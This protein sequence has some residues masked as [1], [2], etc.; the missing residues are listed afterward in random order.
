MRDRF[1]A[2]VKTFIVG[3]LLWMI[4]SI[5]T[6]LAFFPIGIYYFITEVSSKMGLSFWEALLQVVPLIVQGLLGLPFALAY[7]FTWGVLRYW[8]IGGGLSGIYRVVCREF[9][10]SQTSKL[11]LALVIWC[12]QI[13]AYIVLGTP[14][15]YR[16]VGI[17][18]HILVYL[19]P[20]A[21]GTFL[22][23]YYA[24]RTAPS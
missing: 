19:L 2:I 23:Y 3:C 13:V 14:I 9:S 21:G 7:E 4:G 11:W 8:Y 5:A 22:N 24:R 17:G 1:V 16:D 15:D 18:E 10:V 12:L 20:M 6:G